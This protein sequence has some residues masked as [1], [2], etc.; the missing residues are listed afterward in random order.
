MKDKLRY[1]QLSWK[2]SFTDEEW[3]L[4]AGFEAILCPVLNNL[5]FSVQTDSCPTGGVS[6]LKILCCKMPMIQEYFK[7][8]DAAFADKIEEL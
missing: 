6:W 5:S 8:V 2:I 3:E 1:P 4:I 7:I